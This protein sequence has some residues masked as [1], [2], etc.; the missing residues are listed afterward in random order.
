VL[1]YPLSIFFLTLPLF[2][3]LFLH[4]W[5]F[6]L[7]FTSILHKVFY[8][9]TVPEFTDFQDWCDDNLSF[10]DCLFSFETQKPMTRLIGDDVWTS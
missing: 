7:A 1:V 10:E 6:S 5:K 8:L 4:E 9:L 3:F 2:T